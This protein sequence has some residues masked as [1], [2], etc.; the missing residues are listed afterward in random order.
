MLKLQYLLYFEHTSG[1]LQGLVLGP[2]CFTVRH[3]LLSAL[4]VGVWLTQERT[5][6]AL[7]PSAARSVTLSCWQATSAMRTGEQEGCSYRGFPSD[8]AERWMKLQ[9]KKARGKKRM[10]V[11]VEDK[12]VSLI[13]IYLK[14]HLQM[15]I[16]ASDI[17][18]CLMLDA[19]LKAQSENVTTMK[20]I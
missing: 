19:S 13:I 1:V 12:C 8:W 14:S 20:Y 18:C 6:T 5:K 2:A 15:L 16:T 9:K 17:N 11:E 4:A 10:V 7:L 3:L